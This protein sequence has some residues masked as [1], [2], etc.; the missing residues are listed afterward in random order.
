MKTRFMRLWE[1]VFVLGIVFTSVASAQQGASDGQWHE[2]G[3]DKGATRYSNLD[4]ITRD[5]LSNLKIAW[6]W[7]SID[8]RA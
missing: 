5:N 3:A 1:Q 6:Q 7:N 2:H 8:C 4:Q